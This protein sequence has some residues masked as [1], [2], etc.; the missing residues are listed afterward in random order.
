MSLT[1]VMGHAGFGGYAQAGF[2]ISLIAFVGIV[3][4]VARRPRAEMKA[5]ANLVLDDD[6]GQNA[7][8]RQS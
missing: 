1:D 4:W 2:V 3:A 7:Q 6:A 8:G 5:H